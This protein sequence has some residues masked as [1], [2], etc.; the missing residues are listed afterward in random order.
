MEFRCWMG[1]TIEGK[2]YIIAE[3]IRYKEKTSD[4]VWT[5]YK[6]ITNDTNAHIWL[7][8]TDDGLSC[9]ISSSAG[10]NVPKGYRLHDS[11]TEVVTGVWGDT[12]VAV[13][14]ETRYEQYESADG[15]NTFF[16]EYWNGSRSSSQGGKIS[17]S[18]IIADTDTDTSTRQKVR[19]IYRRLRLRNSL[20]EPVAGLAGA[21]VILLLSVAPDF[22]M[23]DYWHA[24]RDFV[25][26]PYVMHERLSDAPYYTE[27]QEEDGAR[28]YTAQVDAGSAAL[29]LIEGVDGR[30]EDAYERLGDAEH[31]IIIRTQEETARITSAAD[32]TTHIILTET[33]P[34][35]T[36]AAEKLERGYV[37][38][39]YAE[40]VRT[41]DQRGRAVVVLQESPRADTPSA[42]PADRAASA[43]AAAPPTT[44]PA[45]TT[46]ASEET[47]RRMR[48]LAH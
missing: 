9:I 7:S 14:D 22:D 1:V 37:L 15:K 5:E 12:D 11:G 40:L 35:L 4:D 43:T 26:L 42:A 6:L 23:R 44:A 48:H 20:I 36:P 41:G 27:Q 17:A 25:N 39:R 19:A 47:P 13:G 29:D 45:P 21:C 16:V 18:T 24:F 38:M 32:G 2:S 28:V 34:D 33:T 31:P 3:K 30:V 10:N 8:I 46:S